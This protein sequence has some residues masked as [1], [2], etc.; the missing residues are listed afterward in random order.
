LFAV[1]IE[2]TTFVCCVAVGNTVSWRQT[3]VLLFTRVTMVVNAWEPPIPTN[4]GVQL[5]MEAPTVSR[6]GLAE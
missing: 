6:V 1:K 4:V 2:G 5:A 3:C